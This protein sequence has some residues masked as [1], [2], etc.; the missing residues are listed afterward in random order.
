M[1]IIED[2]KRAGKPND[3]DFFQSFSL[4]N[5]NERDICDACEYAARHNHIPLFE[6]AYSRVADSHSLLVN[7]KSLNAASLSG[8]AFVLEY[9]LKSSRPNPTDIKK[10]YHNAA[11][12]GHDVFIDSLIQKVGLSPE[13][14]IAVLISASRRGQCKILNKYA[15]IT[16]N[17]DVFGLLFYAAV[18]N[19]HLDVLR[20]LE[21]NPNSSMLVND[22]S[23]FY[24]LAHEAVANTHAHVLSHL[25]NSRIWPA[26]QDTNG[27]RFEAQMVKN[28]NTL[29]RVSQNAE[30]KHETLRLLLPHVSFEKW[31]KSQRYI[32]PFK[33]EYMLAVY[34]AHQKEM[35]QQAV[36]EVSPSVSSRRKM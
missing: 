13:N 9:I 8:N 30:K 3:R 23:R 12:K 17:P 11:E 34:A 15:P 27:L 5:E 2:F 22:E 35:L 19:G 28:L 24:T 6:W 10:L 20:W 31:Q 26:A 21:N 25:L 18:Q 7:R 33:N 29:L 16:P 32:D 36:K 14:R 4:N 1:S